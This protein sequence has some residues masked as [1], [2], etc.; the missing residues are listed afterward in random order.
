MN[1]DPL[2]RD[3]HTRTC[4]W[5]DAT[6]RDSQ[7]LCDECDRIDQMQRLEDDFEEEDNDD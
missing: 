6:I 5:C 4:P 2:T 1:T 7:I 3:E